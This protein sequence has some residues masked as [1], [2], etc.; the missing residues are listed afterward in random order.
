MNKGIFCISIDT[1]LLWGRKDLD[2]SGLIEK[3][4][5]E[6]KIIKKILMLLDKYKVPATWAIVGKLF[7]QGDLLW[8]GRDIINTIKKYKNQE[9]GCHSYSHPE[10]SKITKSEAEEEIEKSIKNAKELGIKLNSF[11]FPRNKVNHLNLLHKYGF[12][13]Y[14]GPEPGVYSQIPVVY[15]LRQVYSLLGPSTPPINKPKKEKRVLN[16]P[17]SMYFVSARGL[18]KY[19][20]KWLRFYKAKAGIDMA[21]RNKK[22]FHLWFHPV[23][24]ADETNQMFEELERILIYVQVKVNAKKLNALTM[25]SL[26][27][28]FNK[29]FN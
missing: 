22:V 28:E 14:R 17:G 5:K 27:S 19:I 23:D 4:K 18:R 29:T 13:S 10:F 26:A 25:G 16:I 24:F 15:F 1:E 20:P 9:I 7:E 21:I 12:T 8:Y 2:Y 3:T 11:V 6:R